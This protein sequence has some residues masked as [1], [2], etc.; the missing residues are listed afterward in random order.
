MTEIIKPTINLNGTAAKS[1]MEGYLDIIQ[2]AH[3]LEGVLGSYRP[4]GRDYQTARH[5]KFDIAVAQHQARI[6]RV[7]RI[8]AEITEIA[9]SVA[10]QVRD[11][12]IK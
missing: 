5:G 6:E 3:I 1:L 8:R 12:G 9:E 10:R 2:A 7:V 11:R 4:H